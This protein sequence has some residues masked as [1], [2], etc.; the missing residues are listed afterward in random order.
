MVTNLHPTTLDEALSLLAQSSLPP[1]AGATDWMINRPP[2]TQGIFL[3]GIPELAT[4]ADTDDGTAIGA[5]CT[6]AQLLA[7]ARVPALLRDAVRDIASPAIRNR[8]TI[9]G[10]IANA[11]PAGDTLPALYVL[12]ASLVLRRE[13]S[14][15]TLPIEA[16]ITSVKQT[17]LAPGELITQVVL[18][19]VAAETRFEKVGARRAQA[20][21]KCSFAGL[22]QREGETVTMLRFAFGAVGRTVIRDRA[23]EAAFAGRSVSDTLAALPALLDAY[24]AR[25]SPIDDARSTAAYRKAACL[26]LLERFMLDMLT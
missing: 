18:P 8:G 14:T 16:F 17:A 9:G 25:L 15:R 19:R 20:I 26:N 1:V 24:R 2:Q 13:G 12:D 21:S 3:R 22:L 23:V 5:C 6:F 4:V 7:D 10:N 11:S